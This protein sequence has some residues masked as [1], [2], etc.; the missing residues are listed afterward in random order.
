MTENLESQPKADLCVC[1]HDRENH[2]HLLGTKLRYPC[3][4]CTCPSFRER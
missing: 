1:G 4:K 3:Q 2:Q